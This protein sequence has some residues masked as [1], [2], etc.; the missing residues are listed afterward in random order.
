MGTSLHT[1]SLTGNSC[2]EIYSETSIKGS[3]VINRLA[4]RYSFCKAAVCH[5][6]EIFNDCLVVVQRQ[7]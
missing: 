4:L 3:W 6:Q 5:P 7:L 1:F 2:N